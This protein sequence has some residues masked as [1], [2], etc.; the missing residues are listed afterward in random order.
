M[1]KPLTKSQIVAAL[2]EKAD[3]SKAQAKVALEAI[4]SPCIQNMPPKDSHSPVLVN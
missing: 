2:A 1:G 4:A 3:L